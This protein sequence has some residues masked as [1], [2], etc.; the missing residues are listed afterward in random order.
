GPDGRADAAHGGRSCPAP[1]RRLPEARDLRG[2][3]SADPVWRGGPSPRDPAPPVP[4]GA[5]TR[6]EGRYQDVAALAD[7]GAGPPPGAARRRHHQEPG[8]PPGTPV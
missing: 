7:D 4:G 8:A 2:T 5:G 3:A 6:R 1:A